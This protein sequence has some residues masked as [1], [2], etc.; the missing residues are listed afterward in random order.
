[1]KPLDENEYTKIKD[2]NIKQEWI[3]YWI[4]KTVIYRKIYDDGE[5]TGWKKSVQDSKNSSNIQV[6]DSVTTKDRVNDN[7]EIQK[8]IFVGK[9][10]WSYFWW[11]LWGE[12]V[13]TDKFPDE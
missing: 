9:N 3:K 4:Q 2:T 10:I 12:K 7:K 6:I 11:V 5:N 8:N 13:I 1:M